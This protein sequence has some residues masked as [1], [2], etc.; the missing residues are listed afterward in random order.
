MNTQTLIK[1]LLK[2]KKNPKELISLKKYTLTDKARSEF[3]PLLKS[4]LKI[5]FK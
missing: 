5:N 4:N 1:I 3:I 2:R